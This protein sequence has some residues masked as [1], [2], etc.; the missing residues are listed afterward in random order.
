MKRR[1]DTVDVQQGRVIASHGRDA[2]VLDE[3]GRQ[4]PCRLQGRRL[5]VVCGDHVR[6]ILSSTEG[7]TGL[8]TEVLPR[9]TLLARINQRGESEAVAANLS[10][11]ITVVAPMPV[12][13][14]GLCD[15]YLAAAEWAGLKACIVANKS[16]IADSSGA[17]AALDDYIRIG[18][19]VVRASKR[20]ADG[21]RE[22]ALRLAGE[23]SVL[24]GQSGVGKSSLINLLVPGVHARVD[25]VTRATE[26]GRH[27][28]STSSLYGVPT[29]GEL[30][31]SPGVRDFAPPLPAPRDIAGGFRE[32][33]AAAPECR[34]ADCLHAREPGCA[35]I[36]AADR[37]AI[38]ARRLASYRQL[39]ELAREMAARTPRVRR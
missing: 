18:Y 39:L 13:D 32:I 33:A 27:T 11:L 8:I 22:L 16:D 28:T 23:I 37:G 1:P 21:A 34:F 25:E 24:V 31:D 15:R 35:V 26:S 14:F 2:V 6:W 20:V 19:P 10:Q 9:A 7:A 4:I 5:A 30:I 29:G 36:A 38:S 12:P 17:L 3:S